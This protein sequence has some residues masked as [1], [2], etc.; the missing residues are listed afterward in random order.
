MG[1]PSADLPAGVLFWRLL[2]RSGAS[3][4]STPSVA[5][6]ITLPAR[7]A[8]IGTA[9]GSVLDV[10]ADGVGDIL[11]GAPGVGGGTGRA[12]IHA[13]M[14][15]VGITV[16]HLTRLTGLAGSNAYYGHAVASAGDVNGDGYADVLIGSYL[17][18]ASNGRIDLY[19]GAPGG[20]ALVP[21]NTVLS[22]DTGAYFGYS[23]AAAGDVNRDGY[24]DIVVGGYLAGGS[25][26][27]YVFYGNAGGISARPDVT[28]NSPVAGNASF[29][30][31]VAGAG[32]VNADGYADVVVGANGVGSGSGAAYL[33]L[34]GPA[35][36]A[37]T[38]AVSLTSAGGAFGTS[39]GC[40]GDV[41]GDGY[42]DVAVGAERF[43]SNN[44]RAYVFLG[45]AGGPAAAPS[46]TLAS[47]SPGGFFGTPVTSAGD[48]NGDGF[49]DLLVGAQ[50]ANGTVGQAHV[51]HGST[52]GLS[53]VPNGALNGPDG[54]G[55]A[56]GYGAAGAGDVNADGFGDLVV[57]AFTAASRAGRVHV[58]LGSAAG[59]RSTPQVSITAPDGAGALYGTS[60]D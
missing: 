11:A 58:Y 55:G 24:G 45:R 46:L 36:L 12:Y 9:W 32:D 28:L 5:W 3:I 53:L 15:G 47:P 40:A 56:F 4:G 43:A 10:N 29:G 49:S 51:F 42:A 16:P 31:A 21:S 7:G 54:V 17:V 38:P 8:P 2:G 60:C 35:G 44:G 1:A 27:V 57:G 19:F 48:V 25:G 6:E 26:R 18:G 14:A 34:G 13:G 23:V 37:T 30:Y 33:Y 41:N 39:V 22:P 52:A 59:I 20:P 50:N